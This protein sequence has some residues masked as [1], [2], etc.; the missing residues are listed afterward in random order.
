MMQRFG[1]ERGGEGKR[2]KKY[3]YLHP[4]KYQNQEILSLVIGKFIKL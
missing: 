3:K 2:R 4:A 1:G